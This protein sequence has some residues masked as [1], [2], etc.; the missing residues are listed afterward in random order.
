MGDRPIQPI[1]QP[2]TIDTM[3]SLHV[4]RPLNFDGHNGS[5]SEVDVTCK[6]NFYSLQGLI[7]PMTCSFSKGKSVCEVSTKL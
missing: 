6:L 1:I 3:L 5:H 2:V 7:P 4:N